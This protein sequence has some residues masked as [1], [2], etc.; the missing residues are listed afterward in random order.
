MDYVLHS[1]NKKSSPAD[2]LPKITHIESLMTVYFAALLDDYYTPYADAVN[3]SIEWETDPKTQKELKEKSM[4]MFAAIRDYIAEG[5]KK[6]LIAPPI[7][8]KIST[9][10]SST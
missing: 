7:M 3:K 2:V 5:E 10:S 1:D 9:D 4:K 6:A 8:K